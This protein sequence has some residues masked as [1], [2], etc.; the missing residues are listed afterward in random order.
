MQYLMKW[1]Y[2]Q[3][4][5]LLVVSEIVSKVRLMIYPRIVLGIKGSRYESG[6]R[7]FEQQDN[8]VTVRIP[9]VIEMLVSLPVWLDIRE[10]LIGH[11]FT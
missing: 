4:H 10:T 11:L 6:S 8:L 1:T 2:Q 3:K 7:N 5:Y 9:E